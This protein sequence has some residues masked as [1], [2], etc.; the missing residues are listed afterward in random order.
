MQKILEAK[1]KQELYDA[2]VEKIKDM[3]FHEELDFTQ[4]SDER[5]DLCIRACKY[6]IDQ[7]PFEY[8]ISLTRNGISK[9]GKMGITKRMKN[10]SDSKG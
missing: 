3:Y 8:W 1:T 9:D 7:D 10:Y 5:R 6:I 2:L 4:M